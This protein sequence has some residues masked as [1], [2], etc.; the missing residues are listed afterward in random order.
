MTVKIV[1][2]F[3]YYSIYFF[4]P[5]RACCPLCSQ[6]YRDILFYC[7]GGAAILG[8]LAVLTL[9]P[10]KIGDRSKGKLPVQGSNVGLVSSHNSKVSK[11]NNNKNVFCMEDWLFI[12]RCM[13]DLNMCGMRSPVWNSSLGC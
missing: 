6:Y 7:C 2:D 12:H 8:L 9:L 11:T 10:A 5:L 4:P 1:E 13:N 3:T